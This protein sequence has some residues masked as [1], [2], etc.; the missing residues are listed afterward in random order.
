VVDVP[1]AAWVLPVDQLGKLKLSSAL[2]SS[3]HATHKAGG[4]ALALL[5]SKPHLHI[6]I[7]SDVKNWRKYTL[8]VNTAPADSQMASVGVCAL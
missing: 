7:L 2:K 3:I 5:G 6:S 4:P 1:A 8:T